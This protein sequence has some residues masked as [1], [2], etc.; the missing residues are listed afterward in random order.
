MWKYRSKEEME[1]NSHL[2]SKRNVLRREWLK[3]VNSSDSRWLIQQVLYYL[4]CLFYF[5]FLVL[6]FSFFFFFLLYKRVFR[7]V[8][9]FRGL[10]ISVNS[11][12]FTFRKVPTRVSDCCRQHIF[13]TM[14][15]CQLECTLAYNLT[16]T[17]V[18]QQRILGATF[19]AT[20]ELLTGRIRSH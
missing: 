11:L 18:W 1:K 12:S 8:G 16:W 7:L 13:G 6:Y 3:A 19:H 14:S 15:Y 4:I 5:F 10:K 20:H 17:N 2:L 9:N